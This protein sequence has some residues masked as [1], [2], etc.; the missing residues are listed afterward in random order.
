MKR[1]VSF[2]VAIFVSVSVL[3]VYS[4]ASDAESQFAMAPLSAQSYVLMDADTGKILASHREN[5]RLPMASTTKIMTC[6]IALEKCPINEVVTVSPLAVGIEGSSIYLTQGEKLTVE[7]LLYGLML[8]SANDAAVALALHIS[9]SIDAFAEL[10][11]Q[12][13]TELGLQ[14]T[15]F[16]NPSGLHHDDH[17]STAKDL[18]VLMS[19]CMKDDRFVAIS[20]EGKKQ[21]SAPG[22][23]TRFLANH[24]KLLRYYGDCVAGKTGF[25]KTSGRCLV[26]AAERFG[27]T[28][29]CTTLGDPN[30]WNDHETLFEY[31]FSQYCETPIL[32]EKQIQVQLPVVGGVCDS[33]TVS[34]VDSYLAHLHISENFEL[35]LELPDFLYAPISEGDE[36][37]SVVVRINGSER[38]RTPLYVENSVENIKTDLPFWKKIWIKFKSWFN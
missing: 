18:S 9:G 8:E 30:D 36:V 1:V 34:N 23:K 10:M 19:H 35:L 22:G 17:Y 3:C 27:R 20:G 15:H 33:V 5:E 31:G 16:V 14:Q 12:K 4:Y 26:T 37:G 25:T 38:Y 29:V 11:N 24:N 32:E 2:L 21:I 28:L 13:S 7:E 6:L